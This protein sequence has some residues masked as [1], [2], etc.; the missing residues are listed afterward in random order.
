MKQSL[1]LWKNRTFTKLEE[2]RVTGSVKEDFG[3]EQLK[4]RSLHMGKMTNEPDELIIII[5]YLKEHIAY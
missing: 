1:N 2:G 4:P 5:K 3:K